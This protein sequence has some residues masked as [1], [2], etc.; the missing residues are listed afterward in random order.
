M[1]MLCKWSNYVKKTDG[2]SWKDR[3][4]A[5]DFHRRDHGGHREE[6]QTFHH[7]AHE[8]EEFTA[9]YANLRE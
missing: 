7:E 5:E 1:V 4:K 6:R 8:E 9:N 3:R 2:F